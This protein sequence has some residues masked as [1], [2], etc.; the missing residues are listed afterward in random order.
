MTQKLAADGLEIISTVILPHRESR[1]DYHMSLFDEVA[2]CLRCQE[3]VSRALRCVTIVEATRMKVTPPLC[4]PTFPL[5]T[6]AAKD[7]VV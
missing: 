6:E 3:V 7:H 2:H 1:V 5:A 4:L